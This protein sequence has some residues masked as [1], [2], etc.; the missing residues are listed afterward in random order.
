MRVESESE[1]SCG[2]VFLHECVGVVASESYYYAVLH[3]NKAST[4]RRRSSVAVCGGDL[5]A[6]KNWFVRGVRQRGVRAMCRVR[7]GWLSAIRFV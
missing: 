2:H 7:R 1:R 6:T 3:S 4:R 5:D